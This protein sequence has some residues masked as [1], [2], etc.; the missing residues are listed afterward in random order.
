LASKNSY[1]PRKNPE[2]KKPGRQFNIWWLYAALGVFLLLQLFQQ[3]WNRADEI[4][5]QEFE[6][7]I[8]RK[9]AVEKLEVVN[10]EKVEVFVRPEYLG[11]GY[12]DKLSKSHTG[13]HYFFTVGSV[14]TLEQNMAEA[15]EYLKEPVEIRYVT[16]TN[17]LRDVLIWTL[18]FLIIIGLWIFII[19]RA[20]GG[21]AGGMGGASPFDF[22]KSKAIVFDPTKQP[23]VTFDDVAGHEE[24]KVEVME[25]VDFLRHPEHYTRLGAKI[26]KGVIL[27]GPPGTGKTLLARAV[28][29]EAQVPFFSISGS[30]FVEM[31]VGVG[32]S[33]V[34]DMFKKAKEKAPSIIF[35][36]EIDAIG[37]ARGGALSLRSNDERESTLNQLLTEMDGFDAN[38]GVIVM[39][40][41]N[42]QDILDSALLRP[43]RFDR[44]IY[45]ELPNQTEREAIFKVHLRKI[46]LAEEIK[47]DM[48]ATQTPGFSGADIANICNEAALIAA[49]RKK[50]KVDMDDFHDAIDRIIAGLEKKS[51]I[52]SK[53]EKERIAYHEAGHATASW[54][55]PY[56]DTLMK[57]SIIPRGKSLGAAWYQ[58]KENQ[59]F[60]KNQFLDR[61]CAILGGRVAEEII[62]NEVSS[63]A[64]DDL[65][66]VTKLAYTMVAYYGLNEKIGNISFYDSSG[67]YEQSLTKPYSEATAQLIDEEVRNLIQSA[68]K[69]TKEILLKHKDQLEILAKRLLEKEIVY[70]EDLIDIFGERKEPSSKEN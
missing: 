16:R 42:R 38:A 5:W 20:T 23:G 29:G 19:R 59:L 21:N 58:P 47:I 13:P 24:A 39:A 25:I 17:F 35:I 52:I 8:L 43:G 36:D 37:R 14:E 2:D 18:P 4:T 6:R 50:D 22:G 30:E 28:A 10:R 11:D 53:E 51:K 69:R 63:G 44:H 48:L 26:P 34:R 67:Q 27:A 3:P 65:E 56:A 61:I 55:L 46:T 31:F 33:R 15:N 32:A 70:K 62:Y 12:F 68:Y 41:T 9:G 57:V 49:R 40:A 54:F 64:L 7:E 60:T 1:D 66:K 45:L